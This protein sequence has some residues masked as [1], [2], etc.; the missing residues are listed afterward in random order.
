M[1]CETVGEIVGAAKAANEAFGFASSGNTDSVVEQI[2][3][4]V[5][6]Y[7]DRKPF[8]K[9]YDT[10]RDAAIAL[11]SRFAYAYV[12]ERDWEWMMI[13]DREETARIAVVSPN[14]ITVSSPFPIC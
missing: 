8:P 2:R 11:G 13:G 5:D 4:K 9:G 6:D 3:Q 1:P 12:L 14:K 7:L 10:V